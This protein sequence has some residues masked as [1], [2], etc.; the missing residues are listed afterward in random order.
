MLACGTSLHA[1][2]VAAGWAR[3]LG[4]LPFIAEVASE[5][6]PDPT[7]GRELVLALSQSGETADTLGALR[8]ARASGA[9]RTAALVNVKTSTLA[10]EADIVMQTNAGLEI[11]V[12][13]TKA[14]TTQLAVLRALTLLAATVSGSRSEAEVRS[15]LHD[16]GRVT[17]DLSKALGAE[18]QVRKL[19][20]YFAKKSSVLFVGRGVMHSIGQEAALKLM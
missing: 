7:V 6:V 2:R 1:A 4:V 14:F 16:L 19:V 15:E 8:R 17:G 11:G 12:A 3:E 18:A 9:L 13:S 20:P 10:Q 5:Y